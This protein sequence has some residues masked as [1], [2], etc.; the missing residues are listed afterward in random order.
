MLWYAH[1]WEPGN[2]VTLYASSLP[3]LRLELSLLQCELWH[4]YSANKLAKHT[5]T[6]T[7]QEC[8][9]LFY[10]GSFWWKAL[11]SIDTGLHER[12]AKTATYVTHTVH[13]VALFPSS[14][15]TVNVLF[16]SEA[17]KL[18]VPEDWIVQRVKQKKPLWGLSTAR[19]T[20]AIE[21]LEDTSHI[22][23]I[24]H[25]TYKCVS[26]LGIAHAHLRYNNLGSHPFIEYHSAKCTH[27]EW[28]HG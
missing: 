7:Y 26:W 5:H 2:K 4:S 1:V 15:L 6:T 25:R 24:A 27:R 19:I 18:G 8:F 20:A 3:V 17:A 16:P 28:C 9:N 13:H 22:F 12:E 10:A 14:S 11:V 23:A 21:R